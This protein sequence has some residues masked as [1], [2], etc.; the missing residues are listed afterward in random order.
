MS[1]FPRALCSTCADVLVQLWTL[2]SFRTSTVKV[3]T[4]VRQT[5]SSARK[6]DRCVF[7]D[8]ALILPA[9]TTSSVSASARRSRMASRPRVAR[10]ILLLWVIFPVSITCLP[11]S[12]S[13]LPMVA[14]SRQT[15]RSPLSWFVAQFA[16]PLHRP[17]S[18]TF[19]NTV[20]MQTGVF[21]NADNTYFAAP[22]QLNSGGQIIGHNH[23]VVEAIP[24]LDSTQPTN[25]RVFAFF[26][27][28]NSVASNGQLSADVTSGLPAGTYR[29]S[30]IT[31]AANHQSVVVPVAQRG[32][33]DDAVYV[34]LFSCY[35]FCGIFFLTCDQS[36]S[37]PSVAAATTTARTPRLAE[38]TVRMETT[39]RTETTLR[40]AE[41]M[42]RTAAT[43]VKMVATTVRNLA[44][45]VMAGATRGASSDGNKRCSLTVSDSAFVM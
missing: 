21:T 23:V 35:T 41:T 16:C 2:P 44:K 1:L 32:S 6:F 45:V 13:S 5:R 17:C 26:K 7:Y 27:G 11:S 24:A 3:R 39:A 12:S 43:M 20:G 31:S 15:P 10:A 9:A 37:S 36:S 8:L 25:P 40:L 42:A 18:R 22:Q 14:M 29:L 33:V 34:G 28:L 19:Q 30:S 4:P 38:T